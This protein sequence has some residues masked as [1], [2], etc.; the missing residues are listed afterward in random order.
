MKFDTVDQLQ[1]LFNSSG[2]IRRG[3]SHHYDRLLYC[4]K[5]DILSWRRIFYAE[6]PEPHVDQYM[7]RSIFLSAGKDSGN[8]EHQLLK[9]YAWNWAVKTY[10]EVPKFEIGGFDLYLESA[11]IMIE[12]G[13]TSPERAYDFFDQGSRVDE[14]TGQILKNL[15]NEAFVLFPRKNLNTGYLFKPTVEGRKI[16]EGYYKWCWALRGWDQHG[17]KHDAPFP[18]SPGE[19]CNLGDSALPVKLKHA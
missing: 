12:C 16:L 18:S 4:L 9:W 10:K 8:A 6:V 14:I 17:R 11:R 3:K 13:D 19:P 15:W 1:A 2:R 5:K 7:P